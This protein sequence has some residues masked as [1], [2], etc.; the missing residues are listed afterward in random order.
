[1]V[2]VV[3]EGGAWPQAIQ[4]EKTMKRADEKKHPL[5]LLRTIVPLLC[6]RASSVQG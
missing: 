5:R 3:E 4:W 6:L 2:T 1:M